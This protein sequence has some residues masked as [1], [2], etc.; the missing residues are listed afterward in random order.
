MPTTKP[1]SSAEVALIE[2]ATRLA[3]RGSPGNDEFLRRFRRYYRHL[4]V[5]YGHRFAHIDLDSAEHATD[6]DL[7]KQT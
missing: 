3:G 2:V 7:S 1:E 4:A 5:S 6:S